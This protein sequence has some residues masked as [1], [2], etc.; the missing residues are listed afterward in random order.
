MLPRLAL[1]TTVVLWAS[2]FPAIRAA[3]DG[4]SA[5]HLSVLRLLV[6]ALALGLVAAVRGVRLPARRDLPAIAGLGL[7]GMAAYQVL[8][9]SGERTVPAGTA[10]LIVNVSPVIVALVATTVLGERLTRTG[11]AGIAIAFGGVTI[12]AVTGEGGV[13]LSAGALLVLGAAVVQAAYFL[14]SKPLL[15]RYDALSLTAWA[16]AL[17]ALIT[18]PLSPGLPGAIADAPLES[19]AAVALL[20]LGASAVGFVSW[21]YALQHID[22]SI[23]AATLYAVPPIAILVGW[24]WL[25]ELPG[26]PSLAGGAVALLGVALVTRRGRADVR[27]RG[28][29]GR[30]APAR[31]CRAVPGEGGQCL[32]HGPL[33]RVPILRRGTP[34][35]GRGG[36]GI[37][38][39]TPDPEAA[40]HQEGPLADRARA[41]Q[42]AELDGRA[43]GVEEG[44]DVQQPLV[45]Q[46]AV[47]DDVD[48]DEAVRGAV[49]AD[50]VAV[51]AEHLRGR[52]C[53]APVRQ[54]V[55]GALHARVGEGAP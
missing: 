5:A 12:I 21:A 50:R 18:L 30:L 7:T 31:G 23:A 34:S 24:A 14:G 51:G 53:K 40:D 1:A 46:L 22:V 45:A 49:A 37:G 47:E 38:H 44:A 36:R 54:P 48:D 11:W 32:V 43:P 16:M 20:A 52:G 19:S 26:V 29:R 55:P 8:L 3:L 33:P 17:G 2:A 28:P 39:L 10:S 6:A 27:F 41:G 4:Y 35:G 13:Q 42:D 9:N 15:A 25:G